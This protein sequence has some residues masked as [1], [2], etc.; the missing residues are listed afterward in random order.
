MSWFSLIMQGALGG[1]FGPFNL[2][3]QFFATLVSGWMVNL[4]DTDMWLTWG[5]GWAGSFITSVLSLF[6][7]SV[8]DA[9]HAFGQ[10][11][12]TATVLSKCVVIGIWS[13]D[14][15][16]STSTILPAIVIL[17]GIIYF[18]IVARLVFYVAAICWT[19]TN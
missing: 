12:S 15:F 10:S 2:I 7:T 3:V 6:P 5:L 9:L 16:V 18:S 17:F 19:N 13:M 11:F 8:S 14:Q 1:F 4:F